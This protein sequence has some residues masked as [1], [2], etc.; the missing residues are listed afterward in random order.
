MNITSVKAREILSSGAVPSLEVKAM[1]S[2]GSMG[3]A[4]VPFGA[5]AGIH[6]AF[7]L[8]DHDKKRFMGNGMLKAINNINKV[9]APKLKGKDAA[10]Q[11]DIDN[12]MK[13]LDG[14]P[15]K[16]R[17]GANAILGASMAVAKAAAASKKIPL[18][19]YIRKAF[20]LPIRV[21]TLPN[22]MMVVIEG[23]KHADNSTDLQEYMITPYGRRSA[24]ENVR[25]GIEVY[26]H[27][28]KVLK[29]EGYNTNVGNEGA[30]APVGLQTNET[31]LRIILEGIMR[32]GYK[33]GK[34]VGI[35]L[36]PAVSE[37]FEEGRYIL[38]KENKK[39]TSKEMVAY[40]EG[41]IKKYPAIVTLEDGLA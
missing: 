40:L 31:P 21:W 30:F 3:V 9:I 7:V 38:K 23:G 8:L 11:I 24:R 33:P 18:Y 29:S 2:D 5:S 20:G 1:L 27:I 39:L 13:K 19:A 12:L 35:S 41:W 16:S 26:F 22:P 14:T 34:D 37:I 28:R 15:N 36:D 32:S 25:M 17:L 6:E 4:S 10:K